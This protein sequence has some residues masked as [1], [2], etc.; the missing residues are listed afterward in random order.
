MTPFIPSRKRAD[1]AAKLTP[2]TRFKTMLIPVTKNKNYI[3]VQN[4]N[5]KNITFIGGGCKS[6]ETS[7]QCALRELREESKNSIQARPQ[8]LKFLFNAKHKIRSNKEKANNNIRRLNVT[9]HYNV[10]GINVNKNF[11][12]IK[13]NYNSSIRKNA[14]YSETKNILKMSRNNLNKAKLWNIVRN[15]ILP[16]LH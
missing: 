10:Y 16:R 6:Y 9:T 3:V 8:N 2:T 4:L 13:Q 5:S 14:S 7:K 12:N 11:K 15:Y 1:M